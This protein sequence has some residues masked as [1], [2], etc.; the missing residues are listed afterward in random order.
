MPSVSY[1]WKLS[2][3]CF[4]LVVEAGVGALNLELQSLFKVQL[5]LGGGEA[6]QHLLMPS[7]LQ[8]SR[9]GDP[10]QEH[11][12]ALQMVIGVG[13]YPIPPLLLTALLVDEKLWLGTVAVLR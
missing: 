11:L 4:L 3:G 12:V 7:L 8:C 1:N 6:L 9:D 2:Q 5:C 10:A 13:H